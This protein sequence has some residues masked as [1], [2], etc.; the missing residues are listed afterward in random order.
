MGRQGKQRPSAVHTVPRS[1]ITR[2]SS[3]ISLIS[4]PISKL[5]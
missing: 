1:P 5:R 2:V 4:L 3:M